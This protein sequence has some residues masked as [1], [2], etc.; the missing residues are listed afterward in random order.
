MEE[1]LQKLK[2]LELHVELQRRA[3]AKNGNKSMIF[4]WMWESVVSNLPI[5]NAGV[6]GKESGGMLV[7]FP[8]A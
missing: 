7:I 4:N 3:L 5:F 6:E 2:M 8:N 1:K